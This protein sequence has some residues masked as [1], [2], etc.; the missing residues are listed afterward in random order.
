M[1]NSSTWLEKES[2]KPL[3]ND[4]LVT[5]APQSFF[6]LFHFDTDITY[7]DIKVEVQL[8]KSRAFHSSEIFLANILLVQEGGPQLNCPIVGPEDR[9]DIFLALAIRTAPPRLPRQTLF[10]PIPRPRTFAV[11]RPPPSVRCYGDDMVDRRLL[12]LTR[13]RGMQ[14]VY[15]LNHSISCIRLAGRPLVQVY[16]TVFLAMAQFL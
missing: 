13:S 2:L 11:R 9:M 16:V 3:Q 1:R 4:D 5:R 10:N 14:S 12:V 8:L 6:F 15:F 7:D